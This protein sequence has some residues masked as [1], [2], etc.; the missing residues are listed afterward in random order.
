V[1]IY[2][3]WLEA[4]GPAFAI[5]VSAER[6]HSTSDWIVGREGG[7]LLPIPLQFSSRRETDWER[8]SVT[9]TWV[10]GIVEPQAIYT[11][12][13]RTVQLVGVIA[14][15]SALVGDLMKE[16]L[17]ALSRTGV[18]ARP[19]RFSLRQLLGINAL[20]AGIV[21]I[22]IRIHGDEGSSTLVR[23][24]NLQELRS[25]LASSRGDLAGVT[26]RAGEQVLSVLVGGTIIFDEPTFE[27]I[28]SVMATI[29][30]AN[31]RLDPTPPA[32]DG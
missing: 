3:E 27:D 24:N 8:S 31:I 21:P 14:P 16:L 20:E 19:A 10:T 11:S 25:A 23:M 12:E 13:G 22:S 5:Q 26:V 28:L 2:S 29:A 15:T 9:G 6:M 17:D 4:G 32:V 30:K 7:R 18:P 1:Y